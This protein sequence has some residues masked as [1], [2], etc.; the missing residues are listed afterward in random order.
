MRFRECIWKV[1]LEQKHSSYWY[2]NGPNISIDSLQNWEMN[3]KE[4]PRMISFFFLFCSSMNRTQHFRSIL[5]HISVDI[6]QISGLREFSDWNF[7]EKWKINK[8]RYFGN[9]Y[10]WIAIKIHKKSRKCYHQ[11]W[12]IFKFQQSSH[13]SNRN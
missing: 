8:I 7:D 3:N 13:C 9:A 11:W 2:W 12:N 5:Q 4:H 10:H 1:H 6:I